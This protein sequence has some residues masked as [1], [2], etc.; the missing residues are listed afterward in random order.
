MG[1]SKPGLMF[2]TIS[3]ATATS[4]VIGKT[5]AAEEAESIFPRS[6]ASSAISLLRGAGPV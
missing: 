6:I 5:F 2:M 1:G 3:C 4:E